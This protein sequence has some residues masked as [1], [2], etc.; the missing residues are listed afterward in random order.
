[1]SFRRTLDL[2]V[3]VVTNVPCD[4]HR[5]ANQSIAACMVHRTLNSGV[6]LDDIDSKTCTFGHGTVLVVDGFDGYRIKRDERGLTC[7]LVAHVLPPNT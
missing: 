3:L 4:L 1:M 5:V 7:T 6:K 2:L